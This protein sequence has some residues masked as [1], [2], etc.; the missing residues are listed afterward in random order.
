MDLRS[1][2]VG[3]VYPLF[4]RLDF[5]L[6]AAASPA[7]AATAA[8]E[9]AVPSGPAA[10]RGGSSPPAVIIMMKIGKIMYQY[11]I[12]IPLGPVSV[13]GLV[14]PG[15]SAAP[16]ERAKNLRPTGGFVSGNKV[17]IVIP[18]V[19]VSNVIDDLN[20]GTSSRGDNSW[21]L[22]ANGDTRGVYEIETALACELSVTVISSLDK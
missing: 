19:A 4:P 20:V 10:P 3:D 1:T 21:H 16:C 5:P 12:N 6:G 17:G 8:T 18:G 13:A 7:E 14:T 11:F 9:V 2:L 15:M 22:G